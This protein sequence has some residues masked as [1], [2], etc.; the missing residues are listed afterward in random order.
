MSILEGF[1]SAFAVFLAVLAGMAG[2]V[3][4]GGA[5]AVLLMRDRAQP[6]AAVPARRF[7]TYAEQDTVRFLVTGTLDP[8]YPRVVGLARV[9]K[10]VSRALHLDHSKV[11]VEF[12]EQT[13]VGIA[14][15]LQPEPQPAPDPAPA[16][17]AG[18]DRPDKERGSRWEV[19]F[20]ALATRWLGTPNPRH[21]G[22]HRYGVNRPEADRFW[23]PLADEVRRALNPTS[24]AAAAGHAAGVEIVRDAV[25]GAGGRP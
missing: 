7:S 15:E 2:C 9:P 12:D 10:A 25:A 18:P 13:H 21:E 1:M 5:F 3:F 11:A 8:R 20:G 14:Y 6:A 22:A 16:S 17:P 24:W 4:A 19:R 23:S